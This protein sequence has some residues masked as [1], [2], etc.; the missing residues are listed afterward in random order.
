MIASGI[1]LM[2]INLSQRSYDKEFFASLGQMNIKG[3]YITQSLFGAKL[4]TD[5]EFLSGIQKK[6]ELKVLLTNVAL[7][8]EKALDYIYLF[9]NLVELSV[10][11]TSSKTLFLNLG[12]IP[13]LMR[14]SVSGN[15]RLIG[16]ETISLE[17]LDIH[18]GN[19][20]EI[21]SPTVEK[22][23]LSGVNVKDLSGIKGFP[24]LKHLIII[25]STIVCLAPMNNFENL[26]TIEVAY[27]SR[28]VDIDGLKTCSKLN[29]LEFDCDKKIKNYDCLSE[30]KNLRRLVICNCGNIPSIKFIDDMPKLRFFSFV[31]TDVVDGDLTPCMRLDYA[32]TMNKR[33]YNI[34]AEDLPRKYGSG[35]QNKR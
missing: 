17:Y 34:K 22:L 23:R 30:L 25:K 32:G 8:G 3:L 6:S 28:L 14:L 16:T 35:F 31:D 18:C 11:N 21:S 4:K 1:K 7:S 24:A 13:K 2:E 10:I 12:R 9:E 29:K 20:T 27:C 15:I 19:L 26:E 33:H 5:L